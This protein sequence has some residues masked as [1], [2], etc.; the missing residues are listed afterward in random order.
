MWQKGWGSGKRMTNRGAKGG[1][2]EKIKMDFISAFTRRKKKRQNKSGLVF[3]TN[4]E[5]K[6]KKKKK[7]PEF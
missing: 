3:D 4:V 7:S 2:D 6:K 1:K 5:Q